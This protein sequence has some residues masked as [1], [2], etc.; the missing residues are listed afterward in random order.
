MGWRR[1]VSFGVLA[2]SLVVVALSQA[3]ASAA[4]GPTADYRFLN[5]RTSSAG[6][7]A[8]LTDLIG[9]D[10]TICPTPNPANSFATEKV[11]GRKVPVLTFPMDNG[12][13]LAPTTGVI[14]NDSYTIVALFRFSTITG[15]RRV[16]DFSDGASDSGVYFLNGQL[17]F[18]PVQGPGATTIAANQY[19]QVALTR[20]A[21]TNQVAGYV[22]GVPQWSFA[23]TG[24]AG[25]ID[26]NNTLNFFRDNIT[27]ANHEDSAGAVARITLYNGALSASQVA[28][29][30]PLYPMQTLA[31]SPSSGAPSA[32]IHVTGANFGPKEKVKLTFQDSAKVKTTLGTFKTDATGAFSGTIVAPS[33]AAAGAATIMAKGA[34]SG[35]KLNASFSVT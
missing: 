16:F 4:T 15:Y 2:M 13:S 20:D 28:A 27:G 12:V 6:T 33:G 34:T 10:L 35:L 25:V 17:D 11:D 9:C 3:S 26:S 22:N 7:P 21:S 29:L 1:S 19:V 24:D 8:A 5:A 32:T 14:A 23:D 31:P 18:Y 30:T